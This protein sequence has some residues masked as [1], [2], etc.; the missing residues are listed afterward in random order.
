MPLTLTLS[1]IEINSE[2]SNFPS[3]LPEITA[4][5]ISLEITFS[6]ENQLADG[7][8]LGALF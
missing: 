7:K 5:E 1:R 8:V 6:D 3:E 2:R 4:S